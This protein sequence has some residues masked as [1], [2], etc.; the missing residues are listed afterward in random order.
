MLSK[1]K[2]F[3][4][5][6]NR[7]QEIE[8]SPKITCLTGKSFA[9]KSSAIG[10]LKWLILNKPA[11]DSFIHWDSPK[12][13]STVRLT[14]DNHKIM[15]RRSA[16][17][18]LYKLDNKEYKAFGNEVPQSIAGLLNI[19]EI[20]FQGQQ[21]PAFWFCQTAGEVSRQLNSIINLEV[22][23]KTLANVASEIR[24]TQSTI[25]VI[26]Q[27]LV[28]LKQ[29]KDNLAYVDDLDTDLQTVEKL[30][31]R[32]LK[33]VSDCSLLADLVNKAI[34]L[35]SE[36]KNAAER[37]SDGQIVLSKGELYLEIKT[38]AEK[39]AELIESGWK[40]QQI[41][42]NKPPSMK[43]VEDA[44]SEYEEITEQIYEL[45]LRIL[46][47]TNKEERVC[48]TKGELEK[49]QIQFNK[50]AGNKCPLC[51]NQLKRN[52]KR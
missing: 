1:L 41:L 50:V 47:L 43:S 44:K 7:K 46:S 37:A 22:I 13:Q 18:N 11:G 21:E 30:E 8:L 36:R 31:K 49:C 16:S 25:T 10:A 45:E 20:N 24:H 33:N 9:G 19:S 52:Q 34:K 42:R 17:I 23:D 27:R 14:I 26:E 6:A 35:R 28:I 4:F 39:L 29:Q 32:H 15:R 40:Q 5:R 38:K 51:G 48:Q 2:I 12:Q 3:N